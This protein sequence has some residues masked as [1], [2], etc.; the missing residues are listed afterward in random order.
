MLIDGIKMNIDKKLGIITE[1]EARYYLNFAKEKAGDKE[2]T[3][4][5]V[6]LEDNDQ[7][8]V[9]FEIDGGPKFE[10]IRRITG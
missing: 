5:T 10:R 7:V 3:L 2:I 8:E 4:V 9:K 6:T 1:D